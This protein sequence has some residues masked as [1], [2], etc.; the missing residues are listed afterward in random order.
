M[1]KRTN[2]SDNKIRFCTTIANK[3]CTVCSNVSKIGKS[4]G[5]HRHVR[6]RCVSEALR[7]QLSKIKRQVTFFVDDAS[8]YRLDDRKYF[9]F[10]FKAFDGQVMASFLRNNIETLRK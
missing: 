9:V 7:K 2:T 8:T 6:A 10:M 5:N 4:Q 3:S 1:T